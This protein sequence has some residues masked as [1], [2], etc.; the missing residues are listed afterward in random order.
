MRTVRQ[1]HILLVD[2]CIF[3]KSQECSSNDLTTHTHARTHAHAHTQTHTHTHT[4]TTINSKLLLRWRL[5]NIYHATLHDVIYILNYAQL[6]SYIFVKY[7]LYI[8]KWVRRMSC[9]H[10][11]FNVDY[12]LRFL[13]VTCIWLGKTI[14]WKWYKLINNTIKVILSVNTTWN[15]D[16]LASCYQG[17]QWWVI[18][19]V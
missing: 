10:Y 4:H 14:V 9:C 17:E 6:V 7:L 8:C 18:R 3:V 12:N 13:L 11:V 19:F 15:T 1:L 5:H 2:S 16:P